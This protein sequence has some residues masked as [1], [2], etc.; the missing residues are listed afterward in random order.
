MVH[1][2]GHCGLLYYNMAAR[3]FG[4]QNGVIMNAKRDNYECRI[5]NYELGWREVGI[6]PLAIAQHFSLFTFHS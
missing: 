5:L 3:K 1:Q 4:T 2:I 6:A